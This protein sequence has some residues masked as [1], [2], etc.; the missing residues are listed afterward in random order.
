MI[1]KFLRKN[2]YSIMHG[3]QF[4]GVKVSQFADLAVV[5]HFDLIVFFQRRADG[6]G[7]E[8]EYNPDLYDRWRTR[9]D[10]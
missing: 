4:E 8:L 2:L 3:L 9:A 6:W 7:V 1:P 5:S 10:Q